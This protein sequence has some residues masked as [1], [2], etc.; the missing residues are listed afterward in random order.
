MFPI[1]KIEQIKVRPNDFRLLQQVPLTND[2]VL[3]HLPVNV[4]I[5]QTNERVSS[6]V[7]VSIIT[8]GLSVDAKL[9]ELGIVRCIFSLDRKIILSVHSYFTG[10]EDPQEP[11]SPEITKLSGI[12]NDRVRGQSFD[13]NEIQ[14]FFADKPLVIAHNARFDRPHFERRFPNLTKLSW[15]CSIEG[16]DWASFGLSV[17]NLNFLVANIGFFYHAHRA[18]DDCLALCFLLSQKTKAMQMLFDSSLRLDYKIEAVKAPYAMKHILKRRGYKWNYTDKIWYIMVDS[19]ERLNEH[20]NFLH[21]L[22]DKNKKWLKVTS[23]S[24]QDRFRN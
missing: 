2:D 6:L 19:I 10:F 7:F 9:I 4:N 8:T 14:S 15:A 12:T 24:A 5:K 3:A 1:E 18:V 11:I 13:N 23:Y 17:H 20:M 21:K 16:I 22:Y